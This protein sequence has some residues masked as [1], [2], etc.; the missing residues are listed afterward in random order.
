MSNQRPG[1]EE[2]LDRLRSLLGPE[3]AR[4]VGDDAARL[5][6]DG[7]WA[8][9]VDG[10]TEGVHLP[11]GMDPLVL[12]QRLVAVNCSDLAAVGADPAWA[13]LTLA[14]PADWDRERCLKGVAEAARSVGLVVAGGDISRGRVPAATLTVLGRLP[15]GRHWLARDVAQS[16]DRLW[17]SGPLGRSGLGRALL[18]R[19]ADWC[20]GVVTLPPALTLDPDTAAAARSAIQ[21]HLLP[22]PRLDLTPWLTTRA[23]AATIDISDGLAKDLHRLLRASRVGAVLDR[24]RLPGLSPAEVRIA[25]G[26]G[27][28][29]LE[30]LLSGGEDYELVAALPPA[31]E[32]RAEDGWTEIGTVEREPGL[33]LDDGTSR[34]DIPPAGWDH[35]SA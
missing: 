16:H 30:L 2:F 6:L 17:V 14:A 4:L 13:F 8:I 31:V 25:D 12:G 10:Q 21:R 11:T 34:R 15:P 5:T 26:L 7:D 24:A 28:D 9:T 23:R 32:P 3:S 35:L 27:L 29:S 22:H 1:E 19:G 20:E 33:R 18:E